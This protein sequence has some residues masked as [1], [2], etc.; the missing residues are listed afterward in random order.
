MNYE[1]FI[2]DRNDKK[3]NI[4][5]T[6]EIDNGDFYLHF[7]N[8]I[9]NK[10]EPITKYLYIVKCLA[11]NASDNVKEVNNFVIYKNIL[12]GKIYARDINEF[13]SFVDIKKYPNIK[14]KFRFAKCDALGNIINGGE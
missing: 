12:T 9:K 2:T 3:Y 8:E 11:F 5:L 6:R 13:M 7:K 1:I 10:E 14:Q 4:K